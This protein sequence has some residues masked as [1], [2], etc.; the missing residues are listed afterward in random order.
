MKKTIDYMYTFNTVS[1]FWA[2]KIWNTS[3][4]RAIPESVL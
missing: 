3:K 2:Y 4:H 1:F